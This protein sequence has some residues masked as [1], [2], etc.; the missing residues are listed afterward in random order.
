MAQSS[1]RH[2]FFPNC[3][4]ASGVKQL[5]MERTSLTLLEK[6]EE[7][8]KKKRYENDDFKALGTDNPF[9]RQKRDV[10]CG[11]GWK[12]TKPPLCRVRAEVPVSRGRRGHGQ[13]TH[14]QRGVWFRGQWRQRSGGLLGLYSEQSRP[15]SSSPSPLL[16]CE[17]LQDF[18]C[19]RPGIPPPQ[20]PWFLP[21][22]HYKSLSSLSAIC[23][24]TFSSCNP[25]FPHG[26]NRPG[27]PLFPTDPRERSQSQVSETTMGHSRPRDSQ[28]EGK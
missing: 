26:R 9:W 15:G 17:K 28:E 1:T 7:L 4:T 20:F 27:G 24:L 22:L 6:F 13:E 11:R 25:Y 10:S 19:Q 14:S 23:Q 3:P 21:R 5:Q 18:L 12:P 2:R 16:A 8:E